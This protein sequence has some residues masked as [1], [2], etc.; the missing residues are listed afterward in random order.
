MG[1]LGYTLQRP[2]EDRYILDEDE[3][4]DKIAVLLGGRASEKLF[5]GKISTGATDD[6]AKATDL[7]RAMVTQFGMSEKLGM[8]TLEGKRSAFLQSPF[9]FSPK[10]LSDRTAGDIDTEI[11]SIIEKAFHRASECLQKNRFFIIDALKK[12]LLT[13]TLNEADIAS[14]WGKLGQ[15]S[16]AVPQNTAVKSVSKNM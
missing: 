3:L 6:L 15:P 5:C 12:L 14:L 13:E 11:R 16:M 9:D 4:L 7:A 8:A 1:A 10:S 2:T